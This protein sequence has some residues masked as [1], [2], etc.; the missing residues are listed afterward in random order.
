MSLFKYHFLLLSLLVGFTMPVISQYSLT[1]EAMPATTVEGTSYRMYVN[2]QDPTDRMSAV[3]GNNQTP[4]EISAF[5]GAYNNSFN[6]SWSASG[7]NPM[8]LPMFPEMADDTYATIGLDGPASTS[9]VDGAEDPSLVEDMDQPI[10]PFF[11]VD[12]TT[13]V[14]ASTLTGASYYVLNTAANGLPDENLRVLIMQVTTTGDLCGTLNFQI[15]PLGEGTNQQQLTV[16]F[17][18]DGTFEAGVPSA[19]GCTNVLACNY[20]E[21]ANED[22]GSCFY[23]EEGYDCDGECLEDLNANNICDIEEIFGCTI[24]QACNYNPDATWNDGSCDFTSCLALGCTDP[25]ACNFDPEAIYE[26]GS[27]DYST[28]PYDCNGECL[29]DSDGDGICDEFETFGCTDMVACNYDPEATSDDGNCTYAEMYYDCEEN[30]IDDEDGDGICDINEVSG[31]NDVNACNFDADAT[32]NDGSCDYC[33][34][35]DSGTDGYGLEVE[36]IEEHT[37]GDLAGMSTYRLHLTTPHDDDFLSAIYGDENDPLNVGSSSSFYQHPFGSHLGSDMFPQIYPTFPELEFDSW[38]TIGLDQGA[39]DGEAA[40]QAIQSTEFSWV[41]QFEAGGDIEIDDSI[42]GSWFVLDPNGTSNAVSGD[43]QKILIMQLT[44]D[45]IPSGTIHAQLFNHGS[46]EDVSQITLS[47]VGISGTTASSCGCTS[48]IACNYDPNA[49]EDDGSCEFAEANYD[50]DG[51][52]LNDSDGDEVCD[53]EEVLG[54]LDETAC[55]YNENATDND[56]DLCEYA[57]MNYDCLGNCINDEDGDG[58]CDEEEVLGCTDMDACNYD[59]S[60]T[61]NDNSCLYADIYYDCEGN[62]LNDSDGDGV[63]NEEEVLGCTD[64]IACNYNVDATDEDG[65]CLYADEYYDCGGI[66]INDSD[67]DGICDELEE[68]GCTDMGACN[69]DEL[70]TDDDGSCE[71]ESCAGCT[72]E[73][74]CNYDVDAT[75]DD[76]SCSYL[77]IVDG[78]TVD[79]NCN[80]D[81]GSVTIVADGGVGVVTYIIG[82][83]SNETG[84]FELAAGIYTVS[85]SDDS[86]CSDEVEI[87]VSE[88][89]VLTLEATATDETSTE[90]GVGTA[91][92]TGGTG[93]IGIVWIDSEGN[94]VDPD[95]LSTGAYIVI[96]EDEN[97]CTDTV[98]VD[99]IFNTISVIDPIAF[100]IFPNPTKGDVTI[101]IPQAFNDVLVQVFDGAG[102]V[103]FSSLYGV[104]QGDITINLSNIAAGTYNVMLSNNKGNSVRRLSIVR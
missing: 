71:Y 81:L 20:N 102:R 60:A 95:G 54:C 22:D 89:D 46:Q 16:E 1:V 104:L 29:N 86:G 70:A 40:P 30:C 19:N 52:C 77:A 32:D 73:E 53:E 21:N 63:C 47:F 15:F 66:C 14:I 17:C 9:G 50:C 55:N 26:D 65:S 96:A 83:D 13:Y 82:D 78:T 27:C 69:Y 56:L 28:L 48:E 2:M 76:G 64:E 49:T 57:D 67:G 85:V 90:L 58:V 23:A 88:P 87:E 74:S 68:L 38:V 43:D 33:S 36:L 39:G 25:I 94:D 84:V 92:T 12:G 44:T 8:F 91:T 41:E 79:A 97:G 75:L 5:N 7:I 99:V 42:G 62:C 45:G 24:V 100:N 72:D 31:C 61:D 80:G 4:L 93:A 59:S 98:E 101:Q 34:C 18:G 11:Q 6:S 37:S 51:T 10:T 3:F 103:V 35:A